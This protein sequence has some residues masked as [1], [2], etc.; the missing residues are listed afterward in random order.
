MNLIEVVFR[1]WYFFGKVVV[2]C[3]TKEIKNNMKEKQKVIAHQYSET[4]KNAR[5]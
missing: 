4:K 3:G 2:V 5:K 1:E